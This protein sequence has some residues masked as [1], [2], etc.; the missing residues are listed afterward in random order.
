MKAPNA[1]LWH[2]SL[3]SGVLL[4]GEMALKKKTKKRI[5]YL[6]LPTKEDLSVVNK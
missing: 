1:L 3:F 2:S 6:V 4:M 5:L